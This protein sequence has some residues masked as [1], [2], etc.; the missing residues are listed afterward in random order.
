MVNLKPVLIAKYKGE[1]FRIKLGTNEQ[2][3]L[4]TSLMDKA[5]RVEFPMVEKG[6]WERWVNKSDVEI[7]GE[8]KQLGLYGVLL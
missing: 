5:I 4:E 2:Y 8:E 1:I 3:L 7:M 6:G